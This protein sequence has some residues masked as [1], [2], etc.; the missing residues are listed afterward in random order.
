MN[1][2][3]KSDNLGR[4]IA[5]SY[6]EREYPEF[7]FEEM[8]KDG[9]NWDLEVSNYER[10]SILIECKNRKKYNSDDFDEIFI[11]EYKIK[12]CLKEMKRRKDEYGEEEELF[13]CAT[14]KD[15]VCKIW[16]IK[17][18]LQKRMYRKGKQWTPR[19]SVE[20]R[21]WEQQDV[22]YFKHSDAFKVI[23]K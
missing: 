5:L 15:G 11:D 16:N 9:C 1:E 6:L 14:F 18:L 20:N 22:I 12:E 13:L 21:G 19:S 10:G 2:Y 23:K 7:T 17:Y 4:K 3:Q 8:E